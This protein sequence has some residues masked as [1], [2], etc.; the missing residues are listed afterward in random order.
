MPSLNLEGLCSSLRSGKAE[1]GTRERA[2][3]LD[4]GKQLNVNSCQTED[5]VDDVFETRVPSLPCTL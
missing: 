4:E 3:R 2:Q 1:R 5:A